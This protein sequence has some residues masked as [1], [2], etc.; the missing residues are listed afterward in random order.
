MFLINVNSFYF[1]FF[2]TSSSGISP[3]D[4]SFFVMSGMCIEV[5]FYD[6]FAYC[7]GFADV[8]LRAIQA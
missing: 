5:W 1:L 7:F 2:S 6:R 8:R 3:V 4:V